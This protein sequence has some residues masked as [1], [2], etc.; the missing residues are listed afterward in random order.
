MSKTHKV[1]W[2]DTNGHRFS[3]VADYNTA[4][5]LFDTLREASILNVKHPADASKEYTSN[6]VARVA[7]GRAK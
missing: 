6:R 4:Q 3:V 5:S 1:E 2:T 7:V